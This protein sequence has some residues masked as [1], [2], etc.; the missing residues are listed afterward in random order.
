[1]KRISLLW[2]ALTILIAGFLTPRQANAEK[3]FVSLKGGFYVTYPDSWRKVDFNEVDMYL[4][5]N[6]ADSAMYDYE[7][8]LSARDG[9]PFYRGSYMI[10]TLDSL[11][12]MS[13]KQVDSVLESLGSIFGKGIKYFPVSD[14]LTDMQSN[15]PTYDSAN[16]LIS[17]VSE[18]TERQEALKR[19]LL[20]KK[21]FKNGIVN[22]YCYSPDSL[23]DSMM[24][25]FKQVALSLGTDDIDAA[26]ERQ[27]Q[28]DMQPVG[29]EKTV[30]G[31]DEVETSEPMADP[32]MILLLI[33]VAVA[34]ATVFVLLK[35]RKKRA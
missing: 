29:G 28:V 30:K 5:V 6:Q 24:T 27:T 7:A 13:A 32:T 18:I 31:G 19:H 12:Q 3:T 20:M 9:H 26:L 10:I 4:L 21:F 17:V 8:V 2:L 11:G 33:A 34:L 22:F 1:M 23:F 15:E 25:T 16:K 14:F 35:Q